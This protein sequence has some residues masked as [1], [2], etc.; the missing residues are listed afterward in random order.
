MKKIV[1]G[2]IIALILI[3]LVAICL[4]INNNLNTVH[5]TIINVTDDILAF[6]CSKHYGNDKNDGGSFTKKYS[7][8][9]R[10][11]KIYVFSTFLGTTGDNGA[12][13]EY[14]KGIDA[15]E[16]SMLRKKVNKQDFKYAFDFCYN[17]EKSSDEQYSLTEGMN[18]EESRNSNGSYKWESYFNE[19][20]GVK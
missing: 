8:V 2:T 17:I 19:L 1:L 4:G 16:E 6:Q 9:V 3:V 15:T 11:D 10:D 7:V 18:D 20:A 14:I 13:V 5:G 12:T